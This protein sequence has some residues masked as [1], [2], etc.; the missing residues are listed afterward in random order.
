MIDPGQNLS[1]FS[2]GPLDS[3]IALNL[4]RALLLNNEIMNTVGVVLIHNHIIRFTFPDMRITLLAPASF[5][6]T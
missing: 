4:S 5:M 6:D 3:W 2:F 1:E